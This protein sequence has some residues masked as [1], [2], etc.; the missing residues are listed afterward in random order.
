MRANLRPDHVTSRKAARSSVQEAEE[1][2]ALR[3]MHHEANTMPCMMRCAGLEHQMM[4]VSFA[5]PPRTEE[6]RWRRRRYRS[7]SASSMRYSPRTKPPK[8]KGSS[9]NRPRIVP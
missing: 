7:S 8:A 5:G 1:I 6:V 4:V 9:T 3:H 2:F